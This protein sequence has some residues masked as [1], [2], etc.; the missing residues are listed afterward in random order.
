MSNR[1]RPGR[2]ERKASKPEQE[3]N[4]NTQHTGDDKPTGLI[5]PEIMD[6]LKAFYESNPAYHLDTLPIIYRTAQH[7]DDI[8]EALTRMICLTEEI[9]SATNKEVEVLRSLQN[10]RVIVT[11]I[12]LKDRVVKQT[13]RKENTMPDQ[14]QTPASEEPK[15]PEAQAQATEAEQKP[16]EEKEPVKSDFDVLW[17]KMAEA[18]EKD[19][20]PDMNLVEYTDSSILNQINNL[21]LGGD[22]K[23]RHFA[24]GE[25]RMANI[26]ATISDP[27]LV[28]MIPYIHHVGAMTDPEYYDKDYTKATL[29]YDF[30]KY[31][32]ITFIAERYDPLRHPSRFSNYASVMRVVKEG[33]M[34]D[35]LL[36]K[37]EHKPSFIFDHRVY[38]AIINRVHLA[39]WAFKYVMN[40]E[41]QTAEQPK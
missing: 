26:I 28:N 24:R 12:G 40:Q 25:H 23:G 5:Y 33:E 11:Y 17:D 22:P 39:H 31:G 18:C 41:K 6:E 3:N 27:A 38:A 35:N 15:K 9:Y 36:T 30:G 37:P 20:L 2:R 32:V 34:A 7:Q 29:R 10:G 4:H 14:N 13:P 19:G 8:D 21:I 16:A 1:E